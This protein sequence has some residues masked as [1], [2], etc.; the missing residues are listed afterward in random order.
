MFV[1]DVMTVCIVNWPLDCLADWL[2]GRLPNEVTGLSQLACVSI[3]VMLSL[4]ALLS[5]TFALDQQLSS[6]GNILA[7]YRVLRKYVCTQWEA[8]KA[9]FFF[10][11]LISTWLFS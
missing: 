8:A 3:S 2:A 10:A 4:A 9:Q 7:I 11:F 1:A 5:A 6:V